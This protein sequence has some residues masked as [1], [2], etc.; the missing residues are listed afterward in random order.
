MIYGEG[1]RLRAPERKDIPLFVSW[2]ND[3]EVRYGISV[4]LP[5]SIAREEMWFE[6]MLKNSPI[7]QP[8]T[9]E[10]EN[11][12][13]WVPIG[14]TGFF[15]INN[16]TRSAEIGI[17]IGNKEYWDKG[18]GTKVMQLMLKHGFETLNF[19]RI[20]LRVYESNPRAVRCYEK[21]G[22]VHEGKQRQAVYKDGEYYDLLLM[23]ILKSEWKLD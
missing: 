12:G 14:N 18:F 8:L 20:F 7:E 17:M 13:N 21:V 4:F 10:A 9:I 5:M 11:V 15:D 1:I 6:K 19:N 3:P 23:S 16:I 2:L 22:F